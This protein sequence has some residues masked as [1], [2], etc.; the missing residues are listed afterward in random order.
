MLP[1]EVKLWALEDIRELISEPTRWTHGAFARSAEGG[2]VGWDNPDAVKWCLVGAVKKTIYAD[3]RKPPLNDEIVEGVL[4]TLH[5][6]LD[7]RIGGRRNPTSLYNF[8][9][10]TVHADV[11]RLIDESIEMVEGR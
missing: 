4:D 9:D 7:N 8:N 5:E 3:R 2:D 11:I 10:A 1:D 6:A